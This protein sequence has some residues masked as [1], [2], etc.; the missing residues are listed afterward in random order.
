[1]PESPLLTA[2]AQIEPTSAAPLHTNEFF[3]GMWTQGNPLG[4]GAVPYLYQK[5][6]SAS[7]YDRLIGGANMEVTTR[8]TL[9]RR[10]GHTVYNPGPFPPIN[11]F[12]EFRVFQNQAETIHIM[13]SC[14]PATGGTQG[15]V[16]EVTQPATNTVI[17]TKNAKAGRTSFQSVGNILYFADGVDA[18]QWICSGQTW[19]AGTAYNPGAF[20][21][22]SNNNVQLAMGAQTAK[23]LNIVVEHLA[24]PAGTIKVT[25]YL[26]PS[27]P[28]DIEANIALTLA[29]LTTV[30]GLNGTTPYTV[31]EISSTQVVFSGLYTGIPATPYSVETG[32]ATTGTGISGS[33]APAWNVTP[34]L[35]TQDGTLQWVN[36]GPA[37]QDWGGDAPP[38]A[39]TV[40]QMP[41]PSIYPAWAAHTWYAPAGAF[42]IVDSNN[43]LQQLTTAGATGSAAPAWNVTTGGTTPDGSAVWKNLG[44]GAWQASHAYALG[45]VIVV[46][47]SFS[48]TVPQ[49]QLI[50]GQWQ[51]VYVTQ[52][53]T[54]TNLFTCT[55]AGN[56]GA[57]APSWTSGLGTLTTDG[58]VTWTNGGTPPA[59][60]GATQTL[61][62][63]VKVLDPNA[64]IE[65]PQ[66]LAS[67]GAT[68][69]TWGTASGSSTADA[70]QLW[71][72]QGPYSAAT[73]YPWIWAYSGK[74]SITGAISTASPLSAPLSVAAGQLPVIQGPGLA[75]PPWD[76][77]VLWRT[78]Q[79]G[80]LLMY[81]DEFPNPGAGQNWIY[82]DTHQDPSSAS[83]P[84]AGQLNF[85]IT[86]PI[87]SSNN[88]P[89]AGFLPQA[90][91]L[92]RIWGYVGNRLKWSGG[93]DTITGSGNEAFPPNNETTFTSTGVTCWATSIGLICYTQSDIWIVLGQGTANSPFYV[94]NFQQGVGLGSQDAFCVN[95]STAY[96][97]L[98]SGQVVSMDPGA[99]EIEVGFPIGDQFDTLYTPANTYCAWHQGSSRDMALFVADGALGWFRMA[100]V[101]APES[102][103]V[104]SN[105]ALIQGGVK[106][107]ASVE[108]TPGIHRLVLGPS[109]DG[110]PILMRDLSSSQDNIT[111]F[112]AMARIGSIQMAQ[113]G[114]TVGVQFITT[115]E[116]PGGS[117]VVVSVLFDEIEGSFRALRNVTNDPPNLPGPT[118]ITARRSWL[119]QDPDTVPICRHMQIEMSWPAEDF[120]NE[121]LTYTIYG[122]VPSK[123]RK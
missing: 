85:L 11:R 34:K 53:V 90:Y 33:S 102:G 88:R 83:S 18:K 111:P 54:V 103:N 65:V 35:A 95:G 1:M 94:V 97:M 29:G 89:P 91:Y 50:N 52:V 16:R 62:L 30:P 116:M 66:R 56:S 44:P 100:A 87:N 31:Q 101:A 119:S 98:V 118:S 48:I 92:G 49:G 81:D 45:A 26:D 76:K 74:N 25:L 115:E 113:P 55:V 110:S 82:T 114:G 59:W 60:P 7:R 15:T 36:M 84:Q 112:P 2:G 64:N 67:S 43:N 104:W 122:R 117:P 20:I 86:A 73:Q 10:P 17:W 21:V 37:V 32:T 3:T 4:P 99:G 12:Y 42:I 57:N 63:A 9:G 96:G 8:L 38:S 77:I 93:P 41:A 123:A 61:S 40:T 106:A 46:T 28:L 24:S 108:Y 58:T 39:P 109:I 14:D 22:D 80:S 69:P 5:F 68:A 6:Y 120:A 105:R 71:V 13:A 121:L 19:A 70:S 72:N 78:V 51:T 107:I 27:T 75:D 47:F 79:G 23:I